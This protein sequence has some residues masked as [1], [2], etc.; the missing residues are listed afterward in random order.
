M[1]A[2]QIAAAAI[3]LLI[4]LIL[5]SSYYT[6]PAGHVA[7]IRTFGAVGPQYY[8]P[9]LHFKVP[10]LQTAE[11]IDTRLDTV[12]AKAGAASFDQQAVT[13]QIAMQYSLSP[14]MVPAMVNNLGTRERL[15]KAVLANGIQEAVKASTA[16]YTAEKLITERGKVKADMT[17]TLQ[18]LVDQTLE[19]KGLKGLVEIA[20]ISITDFDFSEEFNKA[21]ES[22]VRMQ[23][24]ALQAR[25]EQDK[26]K[27]QAETA[28]IQKKLAA[29]AEAY[30]QRVEAEAR[31]LAITKEGEALR[32]NPSVIQLRYAEK[33]DGVLPR[34]N[35][36][37]VIPF[38]NADGFVDGGSPRT[39]AQK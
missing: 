32:A 16:R 28:A 10:I 34:F 18:Q 6:V 23:Q 9:G 15:A 38:I 3:A 35:G 7:V 30:K 37:G 19:S 1:T 5:L 4:M 24:E 17:E 13:T 39:T 29:D 8:E 27:T 11:D 25:N 36:G 21:I 22:K 14:S 26:F 20:N 33:W 2:R 12:E 31:A